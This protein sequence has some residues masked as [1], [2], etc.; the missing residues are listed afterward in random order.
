[1]DGHGGNIY[2]ASRDLGCEPASMLDFSASINPLGMAPGAVQAVQECLGLATHYPDPD[3]YELKQALGRFHG[4]DPECVCIGNV[5]TELIF[6]LPKALALHRALIPGPTFSEYAAAIRTVGGEVSLL[7][8]LP[9]EEFR[10]Q[11][12]H[13]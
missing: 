3:C 7:L 4:I 9:E 6:L 1:M 11:P 13:V 2:A 12:S 8:A 5:S 10:V